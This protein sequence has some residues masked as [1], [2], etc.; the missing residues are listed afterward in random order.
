MLVPRLVPPGSQVLGSA[1]SR[2][3]PSTFAH[4]YMGGSNVS[5]RGRGALFDP[6]PASYH[7]TPVPDPRPVCGLEIIVAC[8]LAIV[9]HF[10]GNIA[11]PS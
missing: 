8:S 11:G 3:L 1:A 10:S 5:V 9:C 2:D 7:S 4:R 6:S